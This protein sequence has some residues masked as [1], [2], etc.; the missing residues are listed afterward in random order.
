MI[1]FKSYDQSQGLALPP[2]LDELI[3]EHHLVRIISRLVD[4][5]SLDSL[6]V[7]FTSNK[8]NQ[9]GNQ[10]YHPGMM[11]KVLIYAYSNGIYTCRA[12]AKQLRENINFMWLSGMQR[13]DFRT[14]N[15]YRSKYL[16]DVIPQVFT[17]VLYVLE[18]N[19]LINL[20]T[21]FVD[22]TKIAADA[23][24]HKVIWHK[25]VERYKSKLGER[26]SLLFAEIDSLNAEEM[27]RYGQLDLPERGESSQLT[28]R[29]LE[30][31]S[32][33][34]A[35]VLE[36]DG[37]RSSTDTGKKLRKAARQLKEDSKKL[38]QYDQQSEDLGGRNSASR[39]DKDASVMKMKNDELR[40]GYNVQSMTDGEFIVGTSVSQ[41]ANDGS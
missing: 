11:L 38:Q 18:K 10:P 31:A 25:N 4:N 22:G 16:I 6:S 27:E 33:K 2:Y 36:V 13:P 35:K 5:I 9:G 41:N 29:E 39:T 21:V 14:I 12:I 7:F 19:N 23:N 26:V 32:A 8:H 3:D 20:K 34:I 28:S 1:K 40:P 24:K 17:E 15:R 37:R 30:E